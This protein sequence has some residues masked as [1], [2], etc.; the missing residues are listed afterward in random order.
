ML[1]AKKQNGIYALQILIDSGQLDFR[2]SIWTL[3]RQSLTGD[4]TEKFLRA[5]INLCPAKKKEYKQS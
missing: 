5:R 2:S 1:L 4:Q 3:L